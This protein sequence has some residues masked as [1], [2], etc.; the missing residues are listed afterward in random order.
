[1]RLFLNKKALKYYS[2]AKKIYSLY[3][4][5]DVS[6]EINEC[7]EGIELIEKLKNISFTKT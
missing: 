1:L 4:Y 6:R 7:N 2:L 5:G 3:N